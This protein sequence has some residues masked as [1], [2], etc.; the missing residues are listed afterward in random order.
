MA[1]LHSAS[2]PAPSTS[3]APT[4]SSYVLIHDAKIKDDA[5]LKEISE[6]CLPL[7]RDR[8]DVHSVHGRHV[9]RPERPEYATAMGFRPNPRWTSVLVSLRDDMHRQGMT[10][11]DFYVGSPVTDIVSGILHARLCDSQPPIRQSTPNPALS[12]P[13]FFEDYHK[14]RHTSGDSEKW[15]PRYHQLG[16][17]SIS[18]SEAFKE[19]LII[20]Y[21]AP[22]TTLGPLTLRVTQ[23]RREI[24]MFAKFLVEF[25]NH[26]CHY[27]SAMDTDERVSF[28]RD[29]EQCVPTDYPMPIDGETR[30]DPSDF[31]TMLY[32]IHTN[33]RERSYTS[34]IPALVAETP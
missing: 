34:V 23:D 21:C 10:T 20:D 30:M 3:G 32:Y 22:E 6:R 7:W 12:F 16:G 33:Y 9:A 28:C 1:Q 17:M 4:A 19:M 8:I 11:R 27:W 13:R 15:G 14:F 31:G 29:L 24:K 18:L 25:A 26:F 2:S 5:E